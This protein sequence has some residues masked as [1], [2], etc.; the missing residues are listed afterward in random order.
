MLKM[1][2]MDKPYKWE[3]YIHLVE[4]A[5]NNG[6][7]E[8][9]KMSMFESLYG[10]KCNTPVSWYNLVDRVVSGPYLLKE[11][12]EQMVKIKRNLEVVQDCQKSYAEIK[13]T[14]REFKVE[15]NVFLKFKSKRNSLKLGSFPKLEEIYCGPFEVLEKIGPFSYMLALPASLRIHNMFHVSLLKRHVHDPN[16]VIDWNVIQVEHEGNLRV[17][18]QWTYYNA[19][20][21]IHHLGKG[22]MDL[23]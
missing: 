3:D 18:V 11:M 1:D 14:N 6:Y 21:K 23:L 19:Q 4:F 16:H 5:Y 15:E 7:Q 22:S 13:R 17:K 2:V 9:L 20:E 8:S 10:I 12:E